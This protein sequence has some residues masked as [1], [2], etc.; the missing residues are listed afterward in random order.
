V[1][2]CSRGMLPVGNRCSRTWRMIAAGLSIQWHR[3]S[4]SRL[5]RE[6]QNVDGFNR[7]AID[8]VRCKSEE[9]LIGRVETLSKLVAR[10][11]VPGESV[12]L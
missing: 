9:L 5:L 11:R 10:P 2:S 12:C 7:Q 6:S 4:R 1:C 8:V 3:S